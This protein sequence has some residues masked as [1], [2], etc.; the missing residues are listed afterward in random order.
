LIT[1][2]A[3]ET[4]KRAKIKDFKKTGIGNLKMIKEVVA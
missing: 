3:R 2:T 1:D 4:K